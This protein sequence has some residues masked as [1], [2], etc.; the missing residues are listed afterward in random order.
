MADIRYLFTKVP[1]V[2]SPVIL[3]LILP[4]INDMTLDKVFS[5]F[6]LPFFLLC[7]MRLISTLLYYYIDESRFNGNGDV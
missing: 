3:I 5:I 1:T 6:A 2:N 4:F 7:G